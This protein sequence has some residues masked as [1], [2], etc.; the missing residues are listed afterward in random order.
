[1]SDLRKIPQPGFRRRA[2][3]RSAW[4][5]GPG[6]PCVSAG[7]LHD[8][9][10]HARHLRGPASVGPLTAPIVAILAWRRTEPTASAADVRVRGN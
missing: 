8:L 5:R 4:T 9:D 3:G 1:M 2:D 10:E 6:N 7:V